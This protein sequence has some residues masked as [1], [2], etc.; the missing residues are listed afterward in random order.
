[1]GS[2][3][4]AFDPLRYSFRNGPGAHPHYLLSVNWTNWQYGRTARPAHRP[5][6]EHTDRNYRVAARAAGMLGQSH[7]ANPARYQT[8]LRPIRAK[9]MLLLR[10]RRLVYDDVERINEYMKSHL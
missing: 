9:A 2:A 4:S 7:G 8:Y 3:V 10:Q 1:M 6:A 5:G